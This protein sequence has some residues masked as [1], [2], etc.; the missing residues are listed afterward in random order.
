MRS[1][2]KDARRAGG[3]LLPLD[4]ALSQMARRAD[5]TAALSRFSLYL[6]ALLPLL[7]ALVDYFARLAREVSVSSLLLWL[8]GG[9]C[10]LI[11]IPAL[12]YSHTERRRLRRRLSQ[13]DLFTRIALDGLEHDTI[14]EA[15]PWPWRALLPRNSAGS[16]LPALRRVAAN[17]DWYLRPGRRLW[18]WEWLL[19][20]LFSAGM[21]LLG[22]YF[23]GYL[24]AGIS[25][26]ALP[27]VCVAYLQVRRQ[28]W[29]E[30]LT[31][32]LREALEGATPD[33]EAL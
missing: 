33:E 28:L 17:L 10:L 12:L 18:R 32:Y 29:T 14:F 2:G 21:L 6:I 3:G 30:E 4:R 5:D 22:L 11:L 15:C 7:I 24:A 31:V 9:W 27:L 20:P 8:A 25:V 16:L 19:L 23:S 13:S 26:A 1:T